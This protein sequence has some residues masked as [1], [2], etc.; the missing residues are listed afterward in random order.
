MH[1]M[2]FLLLRAFASFKAFEAVKRMNN[3]LGWRVRAEAGCRAHG[4]SADARVGIGV[5]SN[6][7]RVILA[8]NG[9]VAEVFVALIAHNLLEKEKMKSN[10]AKATGLVRSLPWCEQ[11]LQCSQ[12][13]P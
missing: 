8:A 1:G 11:H 9:D 5:H 7:A 4:D 6:G 3:G 2:R 10:T 13:E 12:P